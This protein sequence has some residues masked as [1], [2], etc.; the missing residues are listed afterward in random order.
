MEIV[1]YNGVSIEPPAEKPKFSHSVSLML[2][3]MGKLEANEN[4]PYYSMLME[5]YN[6]QNIK[7]VALLHE[8]QALNTI[9]NLNYQVMN[10]GFEQYFFNEYHKYS[11]GYDLNSFTN[12]DIADQIEF[13]DWLFA[14]I[15]LFSQ[16][17]SMASEL[18]KMWSMLNELKDFS[19]SGYSEY[20]KQWSRI[21]EAVEF[22]LEVAAQYLYKRLEKEN[23]R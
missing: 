17:K 6:E 15:Q 13:L 18:E 19:Y 21:Y 16:Y 10:G 5:K 1:N 23:D 22:G 4:I 8:V 14:F 7:D 3:T 11:A 12:V 2:A 20:N 9:R